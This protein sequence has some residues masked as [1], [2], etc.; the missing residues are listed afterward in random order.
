[1]ALP[2]TNINHPIALSQHEANML[3]DDNITISIKNGIR[4]VEGY[5]NEGQKVVIET[6]IHETNTNGFQQKM[7]SVCDN[8]SVDDRRKVAKTL[9]SQGLTQEEIAKKLDV[10]QKTISN[11]LKI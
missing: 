4:R 8:L 10:S 11:D 2:S 5:N 6:I 9:R 7:M 1:V 3:K